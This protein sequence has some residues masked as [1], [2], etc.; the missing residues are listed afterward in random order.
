MERG[1]GGGE[2]GGME[3]GME[4]GREGGME[5]GR[6]RWELG[7]KCVYITRTSYGLRTLF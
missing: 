7:E 5:R 2:G 3:G 1:R 6:G 4:E